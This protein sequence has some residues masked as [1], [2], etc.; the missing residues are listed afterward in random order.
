MY[1]SGMRYTQGS[2]RCSTQHD[3]AVPSHG[4]LA[5]YPTRVVLLLHRWVY[6]TL[7]LHRWVYLTSSHRWVYPLPSSHRWVYSTLLSPLG[8]HLSLT[9]GYTP[10]PHRGVYH[11]TSLLS[12]LG[13]PQN[14]PPTHVV[15]TYCRPSYPRGVHLLPSLLTSRVLTAVP[16][17]FS[18]INC[19]PSSTRCIYRR[20][21]SHPVYIPPSLNLTRVITAV[22][23]PHPGNNCRPS[24]CLPV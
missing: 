19:R 17:H 14:V 22:P 12:P 1:S 18:G 13:I 21:S 11:R 9:A 24:C 6:L 4:V 23:Q 15:Y 20:P 8:I 16:L 7:L 10:L 5:V 3:L 2:R